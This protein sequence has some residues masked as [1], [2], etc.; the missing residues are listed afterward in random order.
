MIGGYWW[1]SN[2]LRPGWPWSSVGKCCSFTSRKP[3]FATETFLVTNL[4]KA[5]DE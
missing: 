1:F 3:F 4:T 5:H 2:L